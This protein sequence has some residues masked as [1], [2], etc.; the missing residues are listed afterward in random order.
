MVKNDNTPKWVIG[1]I[2]VLII[3]IIGGLIVLPTSIKPGQQ[4]IKGREAC[5]VEN[6]EFMI[7]H[8]GTFVWYECESSSGTMLAKDITIRD[9][10]IKEG[11][12]ILV[13]YPNDV[14]VRCTATNNPNKL[15]VFSYDDCTDGS[16]GATGIN[17]AILIG[18]M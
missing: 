3:L 9:I 7:K 18:N 8:W 14:K 4:F 11:N 12:D 1:V 5:V 15:G 13:I 17:K 16:S 6:S 10:E 2:V